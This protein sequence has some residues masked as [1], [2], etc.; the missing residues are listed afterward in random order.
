[1]SSLLPHRHG[2][3]WETSAP[4]LRATASA[5]GD[6]DS[7]RPRSRTRVSREWRECQEKT[8]KGDRRVATPNSKVR[9]FKIWL[10]HPRRR[11]VGDRGR[12]SRII[13]SALSPCVYFVHGSSKAGSS[14]KH[15]R[16]ATETKEDQANPSQ[17]SVKKNHAKQRRLK[18]EEKA[19]SS[20]PSIQKS[21]GRPRKTHGDKAE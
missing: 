15:L 3:H 13:S 21:A 7:I 17:H 5:V 16:R 2:P 11:A 12:Q 8:K 6:T 9:V 14:Q 18:R 19:E 10:Q 1:M 20:L 4:G